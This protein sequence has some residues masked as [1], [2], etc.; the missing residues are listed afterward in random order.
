M[1]GIFP[2]KPSILGSPHD[3]GTP[4]LLLASLFIFLAEATNASTGSAE[5]R[6]RTTQPFSTKFA[7]MGSSVSLR[8]GPGVVAGSSRA[9]GGPETCPIDQGDPR[10]GLLLTFVMSCG[11]LSQLNDHCYPVMTMRRSP[12]STS[13]CQVSQN[14]SKKTSTGAP[15]YLE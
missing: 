1:N 9:Q 5:L 14:C 6:P 8:S 15:G 7:S 2:H 11:F 13:N 4:H 10:R 12:V 3:Y